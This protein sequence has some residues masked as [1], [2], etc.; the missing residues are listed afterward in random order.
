MRKRLLVIIF[1]LGCSCIYFVSCSS[2]RIEKDMASAK[3][4]SPKEEEGRIVFKNRCQKCH[5]NGESGV[6]PPI[7]TI[8]M[9]GFLLRERVRSRAFLLWTGRMPSFDKHEISDKEM[10]SLIAY[11]KYMR[12]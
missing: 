9:P 1:I 8:K 3:E 6:G 4:R 2:R 7:N 11:L 10:N 5:P 12:K